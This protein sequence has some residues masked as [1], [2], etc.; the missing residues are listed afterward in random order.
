MVTRQSGIPAPRT[1]R[2]YA[3]CAYAALR[4]RPALL[5]LRVVG[6]AEGRR[7]NRRWRARDQATNVLSFP[8]PELPGVRPPLLGDIVLCAPT[9]TREARERGIAA[10]AHWAHLV[11]HGVLHLL[12]HTHD[13]AND[14]RRMQ[15]LERRVLAGLDFSDPYA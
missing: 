4:R 3:N 7:L 1:L 2:R 8:H 12:G 10:H 9:I 14:T 5:T 13:R 6:E 11:T 15:A